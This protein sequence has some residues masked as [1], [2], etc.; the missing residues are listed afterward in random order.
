M[1]IGA[2]AGLIQ[3]IYLTE[4]PNTITVGG[5]IKSGS[6]NVTDVNEKH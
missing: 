2:A 1:T 5:S 6:G 3:D 4:I